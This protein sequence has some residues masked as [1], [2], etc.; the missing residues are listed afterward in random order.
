MATVMM[1]GVLIQIP[2]PSKTVPTVAL[3]HR[4]QRRRR[5]DLSRRREGGKEDKEA[6]NREAGK[7]IHRKKGFPFLT[8]FL[9]FLSSFA[10]S[11]EIFL[12][13]NPDATLALRALRWRDL[14]NNARPDT[15][16]HG[17]A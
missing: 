1:H 9:V 12:S 3:L 11:R 2:L 5:E 10:P 15:V 7:N 17:A 8:I 6:K 13:L 16:F 4:R 14:C